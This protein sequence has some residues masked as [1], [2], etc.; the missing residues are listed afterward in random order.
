MAD[1]PKHGGARPNAG[2]KAVD[3]AVRLKSTSVK[4]SD[5]HR[6]KLKQLGGS[7]WIRRKIEEA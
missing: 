5:E 3:G 2:R 1:K 7:P 6:A 4:L